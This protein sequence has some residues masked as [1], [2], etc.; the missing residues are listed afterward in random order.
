[1]SSLQNTTLHHASNLTVIQSQYEGNNNS[2][3]KHWL[4]L[5]GLNIEGNKKDSVGYLRLEQWELEGKEEI[6]K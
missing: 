5:L 2:E 4:G 1:M 6:N 3:H